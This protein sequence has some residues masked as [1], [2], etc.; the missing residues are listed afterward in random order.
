TSMHGPAV[1]A[2]AEH[3]TPAAPNGDPVMTTS[4]PVAAPDQVDAEKHVPVEGPT[5]ACTAEAPVVQLTS[6]VGARVLTPLITTAVSS[7]VLFTVRPCRPA[8]P[9]ESV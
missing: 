9:V 7:T 4:Y 2:S 6:T 8:R 5:S 1:D 3:R